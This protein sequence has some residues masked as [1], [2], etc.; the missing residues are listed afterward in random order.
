MKFLTRE[1]HLI[2]CF[3]QSAT[4]TL[5]TID[6]EIY[7]QG[8]VDSYY[9]IYSSPVDVE[10]PSSTELFIMDITPGKPR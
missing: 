1:R 2:F 7:K 6:D 9:L 8:E 10:L 3:F 4:L 5:T